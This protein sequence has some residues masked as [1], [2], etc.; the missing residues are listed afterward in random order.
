MEKCWKSRWESQLPSHPRQTDNDCSK[1][2][3]KQ[4]S[5]C[6]PWNHFFCFVLFFWHF[7]KNYWSHQSNFCWCRGKLSGGYV[8]NNHQKTKR[9]QGRLLKCSTWKWAFLTF[10]FCIIWSHIFFSCVLQILENTGNGRRAKG[11]ERER[12]TWNPK[13]KEI[14]DLF[15]RL[16]K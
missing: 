11:E 3:A 16:M 14:S 2:S 1:H 4:Y 9:F 15:W 10:S 5:K 13:E 12:N 6:R 7:R 8:S